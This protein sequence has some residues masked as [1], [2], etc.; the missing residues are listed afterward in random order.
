M[1]GIGVGTAILAVALIVL[2]TFLSRIFGST[3]D[4]LKGEQL[5]LNTTTN[6]A[7]ESTGAMVEP[8]AATVFSPGGEADAPNLAG[9]AIDGDPATVWPTDTYTDAVPFPNFKSGVGLM[10]ELPEPIVVGSVNVG[11]SSTGTQVQIRSASSP[12]PDSLEETTLLTGPTLLKPGTNTISVPSAAPTSYV[13]VWIST[14]GQVGGQS[15]T[16]ISEI[17]VRQAAS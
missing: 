14:M 9:L 1:V 13:L 17:T 15:R 6:S 4:E 7:T 10:L 12:N 8:V 5:G 16:D 2:G 3:D 11:I